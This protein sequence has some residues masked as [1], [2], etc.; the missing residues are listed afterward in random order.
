MNDY[1]IQVRY[2][3]GHSLK[4]EE[5]IRILD[6]EWSNLD[7][8]K[9]N[10][11]AIKEHYQFYTEINEVASKKDYAE[12]VNKYKNKWWFVKDSKSSMKLKADNGNTM[13]QYNFW[14]GYFERLLEASIVGGDLS[15]KID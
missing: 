8:A 13:Q 15:F 5:D 4:S 3:T 7:I 14:C 12:L 6:L 10:L 2:I 9:E 1:K 11:Q